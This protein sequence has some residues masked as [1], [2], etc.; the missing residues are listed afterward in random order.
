[1]NPR[2]KKNTYVREIV[3]LT[4]VGFCLS[5]SQVYAEAVDNG[6]Q[7][8]LNLESPDIMAQRPVA[9]API[10][11]PTGQ[12]VLA[13]ALALAL[14]GNPMLAA[15]SQEIRAREAATIYRLI[16]YPTRRLACKPQISAITSL[17]GQMAMRLP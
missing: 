16:C 2:V 12:L 11:E 7:H 4:A 5:F 13:Q 17:K 8:P 9:L 1:M 14:T 15:F 10:K 6:S 3:S